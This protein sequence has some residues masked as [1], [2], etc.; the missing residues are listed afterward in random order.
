MNP[1][2]LANW[3]FMLG[4]LVFTIDALLENIES[5]SLHSLFHIFAS[6]AFSCGCVLFLQDAQ[7]QYD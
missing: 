7:R 5:F 2:L 3:L 1:V 6:V 4:S